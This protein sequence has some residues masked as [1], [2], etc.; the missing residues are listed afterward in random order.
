MNIQDFS[1][2]YINRFK[3]LLSDISCL[4]IEGSI[5]FNSAIEEAVNLFKETADRGNKIIIIGNGG[6]AGIASHMSTDISKNGKIRALC[7]SDPSL[8]TCLS[9]DYSYADAF[10]K[11][12]EIHADPGDLVLTISS[13]GNSKNILNATLTA[14]SLDCKVI[15]F[16]GFE[17]S[18]ELF[19]L[20][21][22]RFYVPSKSYGFVEITHLLLIHQILDVYLRCLKNVDVLNKNLPL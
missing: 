1:T 22:I 11:A 13:S 3:S 9:N 14:E 16:S 12:L 20:G 8:L 2:E 4:N 21:L 18:N 15:S 17:S 7:F 5:S 19:K 10:S 6:S